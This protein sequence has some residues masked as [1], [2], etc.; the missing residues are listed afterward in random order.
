VPAQHATRET[1]AACSNGEPGNYMVSAG[2]REVRG[3]VRGAVLGMAC[4]GL[5]KS[6]GAAHHAENTQA[7]TVGVEQD[8]GAPGSRAAGGVSAEGGA[9]GGGGRGS[10]ASLVQALRLELSAGVP[11]A[12]AMASSRNNA[13]GG[14]RIQRPRADL[15][16]SGEP[17]SKEVRT[18]VVVRSAEALVVCTHGN[19]D[20][21]PRAGH[22]GGQQQFWR[23]G[24]ASARSCLL[25]CARV[26]TC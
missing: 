1:A 5:S 4:A 18:D 26:R 13:P 6:D 25:S 14:G 12:A 3:G 10:V 2:T 9:R 23:H 20:G 8:G 15:P 24:V 22:G 11:R 21:G 17:R 16:S 7:S 19:S